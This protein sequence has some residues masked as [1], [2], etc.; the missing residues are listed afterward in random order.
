MSGSLARKIF[1]SV[2]PAFSAKDILTPHWTAATICRLHDVIGFSNKV[3]KSIRILPADPWHLIHNIPL[4]EVQE[5]QEGNW[6]DQN[7]R[8]IMSDWKELNPISYSVAVESKITSRYLNP[9]VIPDKGFISMCIAF[10]DITYA[11][12]LIEIGALIHGTHCKASMHWPMSMSSP[13]RPPRH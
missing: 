7:S 12:R 11:H 6:L 1:C 8:S 3:E 13:R 10:D 9:M 4:R 5:G 2:T